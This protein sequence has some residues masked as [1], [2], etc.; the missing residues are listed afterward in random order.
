MKRGSTNKEADEHIDKM[1]YDTACE[2]RNDRADID[3]SEVIDDLAL[4]MDW[5][6]NLVKDGSKIR[7]GG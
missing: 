1:V 4:D 2:R 5:I 7:M 3:L 6:N